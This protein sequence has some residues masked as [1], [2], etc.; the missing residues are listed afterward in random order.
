MAD[1]FEIDADVVDDNGVEDVVEDDGVLDPADTLDGD[2]LSA[3]VLDRG[4]DAGDA[5]RGSTRYGTTLAEQERGEGLDALLAQEEPDPESDPVWTDE[6]HPDDIGR[7]T[8]PRT[9]RLSFADDGEF[10]RGD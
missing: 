9:G 5:Y 7:T 10:G 8:Q 1:H 4:V 3:D 6:D 2:D